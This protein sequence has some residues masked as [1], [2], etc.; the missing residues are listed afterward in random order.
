MTGPACLTT[1]SG[2]EKAP[3]TCIVGPR[4]RIATRMSQNIFT[5][6]FAIFKPT[7]DPLSYQ[8][9]RY[10]LAVQ[11]NIFVWIPTQLI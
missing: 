4:L 8:A 10:L 3:Q 1:R 5:S 6:V 7:A 9:F 11:E 2:K